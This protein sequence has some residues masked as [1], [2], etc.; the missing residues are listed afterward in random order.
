MAVDQDELATIVARIFE[1]TYAPAA[2]RGL[3]AEDGPHTPSERGQDDGWIESVVPFLEAALSDGEDGDTGANRESALETSAELPLALCVVDRDLRLKSATPRAH[4]LLRGPSLLS[5]SEGSV[6]GPDRTRRAELA[7]AITS[8]VDEGS[9]RPLVWEAS[10]GASQEF[11]CAPMPGDPASPSA[12]IVMYVEIGEFDRF[13]DTLQ[14]DHGLTPSEAQVAA[15]LAQGR[16][17]EEIAAAKGTSANTVRTQVKQALAKTGTRRQGELIALVV[18]ASGSWLRLLDDPPSPPRSPVRRNETGV[19]DTGMLDLE[20]GRI[21]GFGDY[22]PESGQPVVVCHHLFGSRKD[23][24]L[25]LGLLDRL[26]VRLIVPERPGI[27]SSTAVDKH[28]LLACAEDVAQLV[29]AL[30]IESFHLLGTSSG[31]PHAAACAALLPERVRGLGLAASLMPWDELPAGTP[32]DLTHRFLVGMSRRW[33]AGV[34]ALLVRRYR[35][36]LG[37]PDAALIDLIA[38]GNAA[39]VRLFEVPAIAE[40]RLR[41]VRTAAR[42]APDVFASELVTLFRPWGFSLRDLRLPI[43]VWHGRMD[44]FFSCSQAESLARELPDCRARFRDDWGHFFFYR[45]WEMLLSDL[46]DSAN[47]D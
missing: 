7:R 40:R 2:H 1:A 38:R 29:D 19:N 27:G 16:S 20:D 6:V 17:I 39:D 21:L 43:R 8:V 37:R 44:D 5:L 15:H 42:V 33:P 45:E 3:A 30:G 4:R 10:N 36:Q 46:L 22:G 32:V 31:G 11:L 13:C 24:P 41:N 25:D 26:D 18:N 28:G 9:R 47:G 34:R 14:A 23:T 12:M 35:A